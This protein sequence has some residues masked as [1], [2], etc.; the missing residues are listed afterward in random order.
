MPF[1]TKIMENAEWNFAW[2]FAC[3]GILLVS[4]GDIIEDA[5]N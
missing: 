3:L 5:E 1:Y 2:N 4:Y